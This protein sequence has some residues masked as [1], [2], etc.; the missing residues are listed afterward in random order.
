MPNFTWEQIDGIRT[1]IAPPAEGFTVEE[2]GLRY[3][4][5]RMAAICE[6]DGLVRA[7]KLTRFIRSEY[8]PNGRHRKTYYHPTA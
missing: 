6:L 5:P 1:A 3:N 2:Y 7:G 4:L 8:T